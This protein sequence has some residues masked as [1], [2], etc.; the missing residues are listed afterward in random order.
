MVVH[1]QG[2]T[3]NVSKLAGSLG[4]DGKAVRHYMDLLEGLYLLFSEFILERK[5]P[6]AVPSVFTTDYPDF[7]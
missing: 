6:K 5:M 4:I 2:C 3:V 1:K 7:N